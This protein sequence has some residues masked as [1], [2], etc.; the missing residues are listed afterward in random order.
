MNNDHLKSPEEV[1]ELMQNLLTGEEIDDGYQV[2]DE[3]KPGHKSTEGSRE[4]DKDQLTG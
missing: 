1:S 3:L 2:P 4:K